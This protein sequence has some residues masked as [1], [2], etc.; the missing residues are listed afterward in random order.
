[1]RL[2]DLIETQIDEVSMSL[3]AL[4]DFAKTPFAQSMTAGFEA[5]LIIPN[6]R[7]EDDY[8]SEPDYDMDERINDWDDI[9]DFFVGD[10]NTRRTVD[11]AIEEMQEEFF[12]DGSDAFS[13]EMQDEIIDYIRAAAKDDGMS[14]EEIDAMI[15]DPNDNSDY[16]KYQDNAREEDRK[17]VV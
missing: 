2:I 9:R 5:E 1:M 8:E 10:Y 14:Q 16:E 7:G 6:V 12:S 4:Q 17:S 13:E 15:E 3:G 11:R